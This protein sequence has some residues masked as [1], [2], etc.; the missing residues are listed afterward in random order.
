MLEEF[1]KEVATAYKQQKA[2]YEERYKNGEFFNVFNILGLSSKETR[3]HSAFLAELLNPHG[4][5][6]MGDTFLKGFIS[7]MHL[8]NLQLDLRHAYVEVERVI[9][10][11]DENYD[12]GGRIDIIVVSGDKAIIIENKIYAS[13]QY[14]QLVRYNNYAKESFTDYRLL[15]LTLNKDA[16]SEVS[17]LSDSGQLMPSIDYYPITY[18]DDVITWLDKC[19]FGI[20]NLSSVAVIVNQYINLLKELTYKMEENSIVLDVMKKEENWSYTLEVLKN[21]D[22]WKNE[23]WNSF[24]RLMK[25]RIEAKHWILENDGL[26]EFSVY[27][28][29]KAEFF[30]RISKVGDGA[31]IGVTCETEKTPQECLPGLD[32]AEPLWPFGWKWLE[33]DYRYFLPQ[34]DPNSFEYLFPDYREIFADYL[35]HEISTIM[36][37]AE[38]CGI[39][40]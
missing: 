12:N 3:T 30:I 31:Y 33:R 24:V 11:I 25:E 23:V 14:K 7:C 32:S 8:E 37:E 35:L 18:R 26:G 2:I 20:P 38:E 39:D 6:G 21:G 4:S 16:A 1:F 40:I 36:Q 34:I 10:E 19:V 27:T 9:G 29:K 22:S 17:T 15:Y 5:H 13:D 28:H